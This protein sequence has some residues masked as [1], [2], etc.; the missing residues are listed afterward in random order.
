VASDE[1]AGV[2][3]SETVVGEPRMVG[4][5]R[6]TTA[7]AGV[8]LKM[9][10]QRVWNPTGRGDLPA[11]GPRHSARRLTLPDVQRPAVL[12]APIRG[13]QAARPPHCPT[14]DARALIR[15]GRLRQRPDRRYPVSRP[16]VEELAR[17]SGVDARAGPIPFGPVGRM[18]TSAAARILGRS[19]QQTRALAAAGP[20]PA[21]RDHR[22]SYYW[23]RADQITPVARAR[24]ARQ[25]RV[26]SRLAGGSEPPS[27]PRI[28]VN[29]AVGGCRRR[30]RCGGPAWSAGEP[31][32]DR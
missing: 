4:D 26:I 16:Q 11:S 17:R 14:G 6:I 25:N 5:P 7:Q 18:P 3:A 30:S 23:Y 19:R 15:A 2:P 12:G 24:Q 8:L 10:R 28:V 27:V 22:G 20:I 29:H 13:G 21:V 1:V 9:T 32:S 31:T